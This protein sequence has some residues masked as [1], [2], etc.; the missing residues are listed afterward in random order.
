MLNVLL[1]STDGWMDGWM[2]GWDAILMIRNE[3]NER[4]SVQLRTLT[5]SKE[6]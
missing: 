3:E 4:N 2:D 1:F 6:S 5:C